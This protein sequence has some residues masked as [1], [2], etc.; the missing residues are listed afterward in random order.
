ML[1]ERSHSH[2]NWRPRILVVKKAL[3]LEPY[4]WR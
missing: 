2:G 3:V 4:S 1:T